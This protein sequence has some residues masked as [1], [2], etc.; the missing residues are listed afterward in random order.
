VLVS[1][2]DAPTA[3][4]ELSK[5]GAQQIGTLSIGGSTWALPHGMTL[6]LIEGHEPWI[7]DALSHPAHDDTGLPVIALP[8]LVLMKL[9]AG[10]VQ[11]LA[12]ITRMLGQADDA[13]L[14]DVRTTVQRYMPDAVEDIESM[15]TLGK[16]ELE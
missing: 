7:N 11:D 16:L 13:V 4:Q 8:F 14:H 3:H 2:H 9:N 6:D 5:A 10:R 15:I 12:D 1:A